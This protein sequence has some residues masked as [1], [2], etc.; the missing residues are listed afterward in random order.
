MNGAARGEGAIEAAAAAIGLPLPPES[1]PGVAFD[2]E[3]LRAMA[4]LLMKHPLS[5]TVEVLPVL[6]HD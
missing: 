5:A 3:R 1:L 2:F 4:E 6:R